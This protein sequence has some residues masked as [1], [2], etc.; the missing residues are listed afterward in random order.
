MST[1]DEI[2]ESESIEDIIRV[3]ED[4]KMNGGERGFMREN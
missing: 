2:M 1:K 3:C 4:L